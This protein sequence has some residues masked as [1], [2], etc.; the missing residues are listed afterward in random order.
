MTREGVSHCS[1]GGNASPE[2]GAATV[3]RGA[4]EDEQLLPSS[5][6]AVTLLNVSVRG[7]RGSTRQRN[8]TVGLA[9]RLSSRRT[10]PP[11][12]LSDWQGEKVN[13]VESPSP[14]ANWRGF[15]L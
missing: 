3:R 8:G 15:G 5:L 12:G 1:A 4:P 2:P 13:R 9:A 11:K 14:L 7:C 10:S 6:P